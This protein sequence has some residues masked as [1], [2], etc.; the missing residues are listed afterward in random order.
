MHTKQQY[1]IY[2]GR[3]GNIMTKYLVTYTKQ[4]MI[5]RKIKKE[6]RPMTLVYDDF[7]C[8]DDKICWRNHETG[9]V[10]CIYPKGSQQP[11]GDG[12]YLDP[13]FSKV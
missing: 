11:W 2:V 7:Y 1:S 13:E 8:I 3:E 9:D 12:S 5:F 4:R 6:T 10:L